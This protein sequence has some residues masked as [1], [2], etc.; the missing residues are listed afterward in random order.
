MKPRQSRSRP[1]RDAFSRVVPVHPYA[2][3][4][5]PLEADPGFLLRAMFGTKAAYLDGK[6]AL[7]F[8]HRAEPWRG[9]L[10]CTDRPHHASLQADFPLLAPHP[11]LPKWL[12]LPD[13]ADAFE[14]VASR[15][16]ALVRQRDARIGVSP[17]ARKKGRRTRG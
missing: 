10:V 12:Y 2:W 6:L 5:E 15:L 8:A 1:R 13:A 16:V 11:I 4:W 7:C 14:S 3:L 17:P 9:V